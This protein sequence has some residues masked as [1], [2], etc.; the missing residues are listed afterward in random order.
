M[1]IFKINNE[2][3]ILTG[4]K[5]F[6][7]FYTLT[8][9]PTP[10]DANVTFDKGTVSGNTCTVIEGSSVT[11]TVSKNGYD[12]KVQTFIVTSNRTENIE[13]SQGIQMYGYK[14]TSGGNT[15]Y[16]YMMGGISTS[17]YFR[18]CGTAP[19][20]LFE[21]QEITGALGASGSKVKAGGTTGTYTRTITISGIRLYCYGYS[22]LGNTYE[23]G[24]LENSVVGN[25]CVGLYFTIPTSANSS[26]VNWD[27]II[28]NRESSLDFMFTGE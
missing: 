7:N 8:I 15:A 20:G 1:R 10:A 11:V 2:Y 13:L 6:A 12:D 22:F 28:Y 24:V 19:N 14:Y 4:N 23:H 16:G 18:Y 27:G 25:K 21:I 5:A 3:R 26:Q 17:Y 9:N